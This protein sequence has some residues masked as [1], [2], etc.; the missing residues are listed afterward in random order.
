ME[1]ELKEVLQKQKQEQH[2]MRNLGT[3]NDNLSRDLTLAKVKKC[4]H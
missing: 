1:N 2:I 4:Y 3:E